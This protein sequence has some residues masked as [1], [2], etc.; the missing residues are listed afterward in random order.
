[1]PECYRCRRVQP[2]AEVR[3]TTRGWLCKYNAKFSPCWQIV[4]RLRA[5]EREQRRAERREAA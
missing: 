2:T 5:E 4:R 3:R 1:M